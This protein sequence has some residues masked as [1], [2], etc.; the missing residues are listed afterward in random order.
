MFAIPGILLLLVFIY[1][2]PQEFVDV[3][4]ALPL[5]YL[6]FCLALFGWVVDLRLRRTKPVFAPQDGAV[7]AFF[8]WAVITVALR[9]PD[10]VQKQA[11]DLAIPL[12]AYFV[13]AH[14]IQ[15]FRAFSV[16]ATTVLI[17]VLYLAAV[18][19]HQGLAPLGCHVLDPQS[20]DAAGV[21]DGRRCDTRRDCEEGDVEPNAEYGCEKIGLFG[22]SSIAGGRVRYRGSLN[23]PNELAMVCA[24]GLPFAFAL[25]SRR[26]GFARGLVLV[27]ALVLIGT[28]I[29][30]TQS[31]GGQLVYLSVM[32]TYFVRRFGWKG[33]VAGGLFAVP[34]LLLGGREGESAESSSAERIQCMY[35][36]MTMFKTFPLRGVGLGQ[37]L[38]WHTQTA[39]NSYA[40]AAAELGFPG[41]VAWSAVLYLS[42]KIP[43]AALRRYGNDADS[44]VARTWATAL[45]AGLIGMCV[46][47]FFL[48]FCYHHV[49]WIMMGLCGAFYA[50]CRAHDPDFE[51]RFGWRD[52]AW[53]VAGDTLLLAV[54][55]VYTRVKAGGA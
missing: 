42:A 21:Y 45:V 16:V 52:F 19:V 41:M 51:V 28:C 13:L 11:I 49:F 44:R 29:V 24:V 54:I 4:R 53:V 26:R 46:G 1:A 7:A 22:T 31:R 23:D 5:L 34:I 35:A 39:H 43:I 37:I 8:V 17:L 3:L 20:A 14:G 2:R 55:F 47:I 33:L 25:F 40:L 48:S 32:A 12:V 30:F 9:R 50:A 36:A 6:F 27:G 10:D 38:D 15:S 18:G